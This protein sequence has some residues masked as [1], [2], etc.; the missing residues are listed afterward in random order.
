[1]D[2]DAGS[3]RVTRQMVL[4][5]SSATSSA[6]R[7][8]IATPTGR[9]IASPFCLMNPVS[10]SDFAFNEI[11]SVSK[12]Q[13]GERRVQK[14]SRSTWLVVWIPKQKYEAFHLNRV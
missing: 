12:Y 8:S 5:T 3:D 6:S 14:K 10:T 9:P 11:P 4:P 2:L 7:E 13:G 1:M